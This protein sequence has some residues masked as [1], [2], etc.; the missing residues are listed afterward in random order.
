[1]VA[2]LSWF[3]EGLRSEKRI[4]DA[5]DFH[6]KTVTVQIAKSSTKFQRQG[7]EIYRAS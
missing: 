1:M 5:A 3:S 2:K 7:N 4:D 6:Q